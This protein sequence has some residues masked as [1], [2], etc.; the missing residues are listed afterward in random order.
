MIAGGIG[1]TPFR[2][3]LKYLIDKGEK[4]DIILL[5]SNNL[6][7]EVAYTDIWTAAEERLGTKIVCTLTDLEKIPPTW[8]GVRGQINAM[9][10]SREVPDHLNRYFYISGPH[11]MVSGC[12]NTLLQMGVPARHIKT[13]YFPGFV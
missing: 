11:G 10:I 1:I 4:R 12:K 7:E 13:D 9:L 5:Y 2:S 6:L 8:T 3:M